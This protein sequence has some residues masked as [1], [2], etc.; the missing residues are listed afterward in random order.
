MSGA[1]AAMP[2]FVVQLPTRP[3]DR[4][5]SQHVSLSVIASRVAETQHLMLT[6]GT[7][8][9]LETLQAWVAALRLTDGSA[10]EVCTADAAKHVLGCP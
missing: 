3:Q 2:V 10:A 6:T 1:F 5:L 4:S 9:E 8:G 7:V